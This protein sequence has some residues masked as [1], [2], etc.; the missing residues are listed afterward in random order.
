[1]CGRFAVKKKAQE[2][3]DDI[4]ALLAEYDEVESN[5][6]VAPTDEAAVLTDG[7]LELK[8]WGLIPFW[9]KDGS[10]RAGLIN[11]RSETLEEK[12]SFKH[13]LGTQQCII[14]CS[15]YFEWQIKNGTKIPQYLYPQEG[16]YLFLAGLW[17]KWNSPVNGEV[18]TFT[19]ITKDASENFKEIHHRMPLILSFEN[20]LNWAS[21][22]LKL[23]AAL[24]LAQD[25][26]KY[27]Q[28][29]TEVNSVRNKSKSLIEPAAEGLLWQEEL[30]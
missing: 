9:S 24:G 3:A 10:R 28:V 6:N 21:N 15:G 29:G 30:F 22:E 7:K 11:A 1:M 16:D 26:L 5:Y 8:S 12:S 4:K 27:H 20:A 18:E 23:D 14:P 17:D 25:K 13:L 19:V 2:I